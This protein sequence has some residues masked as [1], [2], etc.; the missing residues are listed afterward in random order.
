MNKV[1]GP[2]SLLDAL[3]PSIKDDP[4][5]RAAASAVD[6]ALVPIVRAIPR[7]LLWA[8]LWQDESRLSPSLRRLVQF[9][10]GLPPLSDEELEL[11]AWQMHVDFWSP[12]WPRS[13]RENLVKHS[14]AWHRIKGTPAGM[15]MAFALFGMTVLVEEDGRGANWATYQLGLPKIADQATVRL[16]WE[17]AEEMAP[18]R[19]RLFRIYTAEYDR[20][21][22][23][24]SEGPILGDGFLS[25]YSGVEMPDVDPG[26]IVSFGTRH[27]LQAQSY[28]PRC[29]FGIVTSL[30]A[31]APYIDKFTV[32]RSRLGDTF[33]R[34]H[35]FVV[36]EVVSLHAAEHTDHGWDRPLPPWR[37]YRREISRNQACPGESCKTLGDSNC[38]LGVTRASVIDN[39]PRLGEFKL[40]DHDCG[41]RVFTVHE[42]FAARLAALS[43]AV[44][45]GDGALPGFAASGITRTAT[46]SLHGHK[47]QGPWDSRRWYDYV[48]YT[49]ITSH[50]ME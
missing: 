9:C 39:P 10:G 11:L 12:S 46:P 31:L 41:R 7:M 18:A 19:C 43:P 28:D 34:N 6:A 45:P 38:R 4:A 2:A 25:Y 44:N 37:F 20:R 36:S 48:G 16:A 42:M 5:I 47:W 14:T 32:G 29:A 22:I 23:I 50:P 40:S 35:S 8:R 15:K 17:I 26:L 13:V 24:L 33:P 21:P 3:A 30:A 1:L 27:G 49:R